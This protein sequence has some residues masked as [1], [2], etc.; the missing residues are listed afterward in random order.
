MDAVTRIAT[1]TG[2]MA[3]RALTNTLPK[4][5]TQVHFWNREEVLFME[6]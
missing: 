3:L 2:A 4:I 6:A 1:K 5:P